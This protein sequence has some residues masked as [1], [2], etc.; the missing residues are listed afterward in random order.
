L[1]IEMVVVGLGVVGLG[2]WGGWKAMNGLM[3]NL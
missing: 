2:A 1:M 3:A